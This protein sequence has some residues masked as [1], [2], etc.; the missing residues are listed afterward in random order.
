MTKMCLFLALLIECPFMLAIVVFLK[1]AANVLR[2]VAS[3]SLNTIDLR[4]QNQNIL[5]LLGN[6]ETHCLIYELMGLL[7]KSPVKF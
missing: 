5:L 2:L 3:E 7:D 4:Q 1:D 6:I